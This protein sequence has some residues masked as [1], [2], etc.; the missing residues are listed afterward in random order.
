MYA[1]LPVEIQKLARKNYRLW[2]DDTAH[3]S[4]HFKRLAG[5]YWSV[6]VGLHYRAVGRMEDNTMYWFWIGSHADFDAIV[7][8]L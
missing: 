3:P 1:E 8:E 6:R 5:P 7:K 4:L 2:R